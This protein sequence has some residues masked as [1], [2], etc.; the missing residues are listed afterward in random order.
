MKGSEKGRTVAKAKNHLELSKVRV[1][2]LYK[3]ILASPSF[4]NQ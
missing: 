1:I 4:E 2:D 3:Q